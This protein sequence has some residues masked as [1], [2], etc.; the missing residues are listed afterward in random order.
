MHLE[1]DAAAGDT[2]TLAEM[3]YLEAMEDVKTIS[4]RLVEAEKAFSLVKDRIQDLVTRYQ[5]LLVK[6]EAESCAGASSIM[7]FESSYSDNDSEYWEEQEHLERERWAR[8]A[9]RAE[10]RAELAAREALMVRQEA[11]MIQ[12]EKERELEALQQKLFEL[13]SEPSTAIADKEQSAAA[14]AKNY[15]MHRN[16]APHQ[17]LQPEVARS[18]TS[19]TG[20]D[21]EKLDGVKQRFRDRIAAKKKQANGFGATTMSP[22]GK[23][24]S[25]VTPSPQQTAR[26]LFRSAGEEMYQHL[27]F[28]ERSL[29]AVEMTHDPI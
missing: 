12:E 3:T 11:R 5:A 8:R 18:T 10:V 7:T 20:I 1:G 21:K 27:D 14:I 2:M 4:K 22:P 29:K 6:I 13:Q 17:M 23:A 19:R 25:P 26:T 28:Y 24:A 9:K 16:D 15:S